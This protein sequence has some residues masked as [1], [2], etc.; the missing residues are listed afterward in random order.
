[1]DF[2][3][4]VDLF[5]SPMEFGNEMDIMLGEDNNKDVV[6][7][8]IDVNE[9]VNEE[10]NEIEGGGDND[11]DEIELMGDEDI[12]SN[13]ESLLDSNV[14]PQ[15][16]NEDVGEIQEASEDIGEIQDEERVNG[17]EISEPVKEDDGIDSLPEPLLA[18]DQ[19]VEQDKEDTQVNDDKA[20]VPDILPESIQSISEQH[21]RAETQEPEN[22]EELKKVE[23]EEEKEEKPES[24]SNDKSMDIDEELTPENKEV[25]NSLP[26]SGQSENVEGE[27][28]HNEEIPNEHTHAVDVDVDDV[29]GED[30]QREETQADDMKTDDIET[31]EVQTEAPNQVNEQ[32]EVNGED[33]PIEA[34]VENDEHP[35]DRDVDGDEAKVGDTMHLSHSGNDAVSEP[36]HNVAEATTS[37]E[38]IETVNH[39]NN[40][41]HSVLPSDNIQLAEGSSVNSSND[42][43]DKDLFG[44]DVET[45]N[46]SS[47][48]TGNNLNANANE[49]VARSESNEIKAETEQDSSDTKEFETHGSKM[50]VEKQ[51]GDESSEKKP[52]EATDQDG[53]I[54]MDR[55]DNHSRQVEKDDSTFVKTDPAS[56]HVIENDDMIDNKE[57]IN[58][59]NTEEKVDKNEEEEEQ[60]SSSSSPESVNDSVIENA[61][62]SFAQTHEIIIPSYSKWFDLRKIHD[63]EKKSLP[64]FFTNRIPSKTPEVY[65]KYRNFMVNV[66]RLNPNE[67]FTVTAARRNISGDA[68][69]L[70]RIHKFLTKWGLINY[71]VDAK[72]LPK[73]VEPPFTGDYATRHDAPRGLF[74]FES[75][76]PSVQ[77]PDMA[78][79]KKMMDVND[80]E[81]ALYRYLK[82]EKRKFIEAKLENS[83]N[84]KAAVHSTEIK[85]EET[86]SNKDDNT[87]GGTDSHVQNH[88]TNQNLKRV[89]EAAFN[90]EHKLKRPK[91]LDDESEGW[92]KEDT[93]KLLDGI[94]KHGVD[95][96]KVA[97]EVGTKTPEQCVLKFLQLPIED[98]FLYN[99]EGGKDLGPIKFAPHLPFS[100]SENPVLSTIAFL[101]GLVDPQIVKNMTNRAIQKIEDVHDQNLKNTKNDAKEGSEIAL[102]SLGVRSGIYANNEEK[103]LHALSHELVQVQLQKLETKLDLLNKMEK[104]F[105]LEKKLLEKQQETLLM[106]RL[107]SVKNTKAVADITSKIIDE[108]DD[109]EE[110]KKHLETL[111]DQIAN[112]ITPSF[113]IPTEVSKSTT[114]L[115]EPKEVKP[116]SIEAPQFYRYWSA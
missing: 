66:Y 96:Y 89:H 51:D 29:K 1:M 106:Q 90:E 53:D 48:E 70:F 64:E 14:I 65:V 23:E 37:K 39:N 72:V 38:H 35:K 22:E 69:A 19:K 76:K 46:E 10:V 28:A 45:G 7:A 93:Q 74:P 59:R 104:T 110:L 44:E 30:A 5:G 34:A 103:H 114:T 20:V 102:A 86:T 95:W 92:K 88:H 4:D 36:N 81:S 41:Q 75:Y 91:I 82:E 116:V 79:L 100:K 26:E 21:E 83:S 40:D 55:D 47:G 113:A 12:E 16:A 67:Y 9:D 13:T 56:S 42:E 84:Q 97:S 99:G 109:K 68:A 17:V 24:Q 58:N 49:D 8:G 54:D 15:G 101:V 105:D 3:E 18:T 112:P 108:I 80:S 32:Q 87:S 50:V 107:Q 31:E 111:R 25:E 6:E 27:N 61:P 2:N 33:V 52:L 60:P 115:S 62:Y 11:E 43:D 94:Q 78:K 63:I 98:K 85:H 77:L 71:Q 73:N 57:P